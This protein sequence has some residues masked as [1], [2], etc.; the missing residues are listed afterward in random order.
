MSESLE[1][2]VRAI[3]QACGRDRTRMMD[4][5][6]A[7]QQKF[8]CVSGPALELIA[9]DTSVHRVEVESVVSFYTFLSSRP[10]GHVVIRLC[11]DVIDEM[12]GAREVA[13]AFADELGIQIGETTPDGK[14]TLETTAC[15][16]MCDQGPVVSVNGRIHTQFT[17]D[18]VGALLRDCLGGG[19]MVAA[20]GRD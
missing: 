9:K 19:D 2:T 7:V 16:G 15:I 10:K 14:I 18:R 11:N 17:A 8:G 1:A 12:Q 4:I 3:C 6:R 5:V 13:Q 20:P